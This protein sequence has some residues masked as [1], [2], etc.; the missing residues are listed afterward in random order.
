MKYFIALIVFL[1]VACVLIVFLQ[2]F[3]RKAT[4]ELVL[5]RTGAGGQR[6]VMDGGL[7]VLPFLHRVESINMLTMRLH[8]SRKG[9]KSLMTEDRLRVD[10][11]MEFYLRVE[12]SLDGVSTAAQ[13]IGREALNPDDLSSLLDGRLID[14]IQTAVALRSMDQ[15]H[16]Q[17]GE[18]VSAVKHELSEN[19]AAN[20]LR[21]ES[22]SLTLLDQT[23]FS[24]LKGDNAF[25][26]VGMRKLSEVI[27][28]NKKQKA[29]IEA[30]ADIS[31]RQTELTRLKQKLAIDREQKESEIEIEQALELRKTECQT[32]T[33]Q[34]RHRAESESENARIRRELEIRSEEISKDLS[35]RKQEVEA[36]ET[37]ELSK[38]ESQI[39]L[40]RKRAEENKVQAQTEASRT[41]IVKD[42][43]ML[44]SQKDRMIAER[45][46]EI[47]VLQAR[48]E[49]EVSTIRSQ[50]EMGILLENATTEAKAIELH[51]IA[52][53]LKMKSRAEGKAAV[54]AAE[55]QIE[56]RVLAMKVER[57]K[58]ATS[59]KIAGR[60]A[61]PLKKID[62][63]RIN[64]ISG[65][66]STG[67]GAGGGDAGNPMSQAVDGV[68]NMAFQ[69]PAMQKLGQSI[70]V[71]LA[72]DDPENTDPGKDDSLKKK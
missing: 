53:S 65:M 52:H 26:A 16:E 44:Q 57:Q 49:S 7:L 35:L 47:A 54:I 4:R 10:I 1:V 37:A 58:I 6:V 39:S 14:S 20:G 66:G 23:A 2:R 70:G 19:L 25:D 43:E 42:Q 50:G 24:S 71:N 22:V 27:A 11:E 48:K 36:L 60:V 45:A 9:E 61:A 40:A 62:S 29:E 30:D 3:Y 51:S 17:R 12:P 8:I 5:I 46:H 59:P 18:F 56:E 21:L 68:L 63:I 64:Q 38:I 34:A 31:V 28:S 67:G 33:Q 72:F 32:Q 15:L 55:N 13:A 41:D 69:L